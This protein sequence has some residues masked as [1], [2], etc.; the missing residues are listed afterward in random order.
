MYD[1][2]LEDTPE[3]NVCFDKSWHEVTQDDIKVLAQ[4]LEEEQGGHVFHKKI[5]WNVTTP[6]IELKESGPL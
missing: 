6:W 3:N 4:R 5:D 1:L 2:E